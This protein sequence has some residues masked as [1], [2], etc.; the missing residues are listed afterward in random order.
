MSIFNKCFIVFVAGVTIFT[1]Q[2]SM[3]VPVVKV[4]VKGA[5][6]A[7]GLG[8]ASYYYSSQIKKAPSYQKPSNVVMYAANR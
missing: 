7:G 8:G 4:V 6:A 3:K 5:L 1:A 2:A